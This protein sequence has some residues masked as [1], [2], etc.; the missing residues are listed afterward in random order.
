MINDQT[1]KDAGFG[2]ASS[3]QGSV[4][5]PAKDQ[6]NASTASSGSGTGRLHIIEGLR[7]Q[8]SRITKYK[9]LYSD[10]SKRFIKLYEEL[11]LCQQQQRLDKEHLKARSTQHALLDVAITDALKQLGQGTS[12]NAVPVIKHAMGTLGAA[13]SAS[14]KLQAIPAFLAG[15]DTSA[16]NAPVIAAVLFAKSKTTKEA[17]TRRSTSLE[18]T[19]QSNTAQSSMQHHSHMSSSFFPGGGEAGATLQQKR[20]WDNTDE[21]S[22]PTKKAATA[23]S[24][25]SGMR[26]T[27]RPASPR[28]HVS[29]VDARHRHTGKI[30][31]KKN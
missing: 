1:E 9:K 16:S 10:L 19:S 31:Q 11:Q 25:V 23:S 2:L 15:Q 13:K 14:S 30:T 28:L 29:E 26:A 5:K 24:I 21:I 27:M 22:S 18:E 6:D 7:R 4:S 20:P 12:R 17:D 8:D 3:A